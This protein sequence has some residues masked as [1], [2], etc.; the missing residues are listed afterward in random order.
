M[1]LIH[2]GW[3]DLRKAV[4]MNR[5]GFFRNLPKLDMLPP[6][7][8]PSVRLLGNV[9]ARERMYELEKTYYAGALHVLGL[10]G[11]AVIDT[12]DQ[13]GAKDLLYSLLHE[14]EAFVNS[15]VK[16]DATE[17]QPGNFESTGTDRKH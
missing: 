12:N 4:L 11:S 6:E 3:E 2:A 14:A 8:R 15:E 7:L 10:V 16:K 5:D 13:Q 9:L 1:K 17:N